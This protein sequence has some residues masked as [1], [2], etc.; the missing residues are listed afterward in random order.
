M[1]CLCPN[2]TPLTLRI[3]MMEIKFGIFVFFF[4]RYTYNFNI[5]TIISLTFR[6]MRTW[7]NDHST[8]RLRSCGCYYTSTAIC[9]RHFHGS[10]TKSAIFSFFFMSAARSILPYENPSLTLFPEFEWTSSTHHYFFPIDTNMTWCNS[11]TFFFFFVNT[12]ETLDRV[13]R[14]ETRPVEFSLCCRPIV[15]KNRSR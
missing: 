2:F 9:R 14:F 8:R 12:F 13:R 3:F 11:S 10:R 4:I 15:D 5:D 1:S 7:N 6:V